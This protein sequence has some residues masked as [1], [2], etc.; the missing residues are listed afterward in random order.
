MYKCNF[1]DQPMMTE[2]EKKANT[3]NTYA[4]AVIFF[5]EKMAS[6]EKYQENSGNSAKQNGFESA[7]SALKIADQMKAILK[8]HIGPAGEKTKA[9]HLLQMSTMQSEKDHQEAEITSMRKE[10][11]TYN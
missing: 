9:E 4:N 1:F 7:N 11:Q 2:W 8:E 5:N 10:V 3:D 6:I